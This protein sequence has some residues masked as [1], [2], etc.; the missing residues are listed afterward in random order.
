MHHARI[1]VE[2]PCRCV[3]CTTEGDLERLVA[4]ILKKRPLETFEDLAR[5]VLQTAGLGRWKRLAAHKLLAPL[6][7][8]Q[9]IAEAASTLLDRKER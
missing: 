2:N 6:K 1:G 3:H 7:R 9:K 5:R 8:E 4:R